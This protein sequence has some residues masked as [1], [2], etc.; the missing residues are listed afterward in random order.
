MSRSFGAIA[1]YL[2]HR[3]P[4]LLIDRIDEVTDSRVVCS[5]TIAPSC[6]F[7]RDGRVHASA[8]LEFIAQACAIHAGV[9][10]RAQVTR[11]QPGMVISCREATLHV[12]TYAVGDVLVITATRCPGAHPLTTF[13]GEVHRRGEL[14]VSLQLSVMEGL[15]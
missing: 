7:V 2:P 6:V 5:A 13:E 8:M 10:Q 4:M 9:T 14:C 1:D 11:P 12:E 3:P 15:P